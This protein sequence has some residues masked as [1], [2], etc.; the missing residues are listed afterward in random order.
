M[1]KDKSSVTIQMWYVHNFLSKRKKVSSKITAAVVFK[2]SQFICNKIYL[3]NDN[4]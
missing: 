4:Y 1:S 3:L 2:V